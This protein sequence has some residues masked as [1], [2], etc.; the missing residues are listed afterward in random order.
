[1]M[2]WLDIEIAIAQDNDLH[3]WHSQYRGCWLR[4]VRKYGIN[5]H[6]IDLLFL[7]NDWIYHNQR[8]RMIK[9]VDTICSLWNFWLKYS[10]WFDMQHCN[11]I[12]LYP[13]TESYEKLY[14][15]PCR[16][17]WYLRWKAL[18]FTV[19]ASSFHLKH[20]T[21]RISSDMKSNLVCWS[22]CH[23]SFTRWKHCIRVL[24]FLHQL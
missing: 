3:V 9:P 21:L 5:S 10:T 18:L 7:G 1:M 8:R 20:T 19:H 4:G 6:E 11:K 12:I 15:A 22:H 17:T 23:C 13:W 2:S 14:F 16:I 24:A